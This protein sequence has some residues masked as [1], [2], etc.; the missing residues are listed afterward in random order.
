MPL[1]ERI[2]EVKEAFIGALERAQVSPER[3]A[4]I[5]DKLGIPKEMQAT[6]EKA[7]IVEILA[8]RFRPLPRQKY[9]WLDRLDPDTVPDLLPAFF[10]P[11]CRSAGGPPASPSTPP[12]Q[13]API[14]R[15]PHPRTGATAHRK[16]AAKHLPPVPG[17]EASGRTD[18]DA[19]TA[20]LRPPAH[21]RT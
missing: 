10:S 4:L 21:G 5:R 15:L 7:K 17:Q 9:T 11:S 6:G 18:P 14:P 13:V 8:K 16:S 19:P 12:P 20:A 2:L 3:I 1:P